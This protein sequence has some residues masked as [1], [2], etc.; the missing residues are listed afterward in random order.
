MNE[1]HAIFLT[2]INRIIGLLGGLASG[3]ISARLLSPEDRGQ[4]FTLLSFSM[5][6]I[7]ALLLGLN[8]ANVRLGTKTFAKRVASYNNLRFS[9][10]AGLIAFFL[11][12]AAHKT[13]FLYPQYEKL[14][15]LLAAAIVG[16]G[17]F[18]A[19]NQNLLLGEQRFNAYNLSDIFYKALGITLLLTLLIIFPSPTFAILAQLGSAVIICIVLI[20]IAP[21]RKAKPFASKLFLTS[22]GWG[23]KA[24]IV[25]FLGFAINRGIIILLP[26]RMSD[27]NIGIF[28]VAFQLA[29]AT[30]LVPIAIASVVFPKML[31]DKD[32]SI[33]SIIKL[34]ALYYLL[35]GIALFVMAPYLINALFG[36]SYRDAAQILIQLL[37]PFALLS[38]LSIISNKAYS[39]RYPKKLIFAWTLAA[40]TTVAFV[41][42]NPEITAAKISVLLCASYIFLIVSISLTLRKSRLL[43]NTN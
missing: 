23:F 28:S 10:F 35:V 19:L 26:G 4:Y 39:I 20:K 32:Y 8:T 25:S 13:G 14:N 29:E 41:M 34:I 24:Y 42:L 17:I 7:Q 12:Y 21:R 31:R 2:I 36:D 1:R 9:F 11:S 43:R 6:S 5:L 37:P 3:I 27:Q 18:V 15:V 30:A 33:F 22:L 40:I 16:F 38:V